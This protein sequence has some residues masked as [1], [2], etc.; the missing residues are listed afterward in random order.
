MRSLLPKFSLL[1]FS[2][3]I[4]LVLCEVLVRLFVPQQLIVRRPD[5]WRP[6]D[7]FGYR[8]RENIN[9]VL[10]RG[11]GN[12]HI[13]TDSHGY[14][15][16]QNRGANNTTPDIS[17]LVLG[18]S[19][20]EALAVENEFTIP[21]LI[22]KYLENKYK[23]T[24]QVDNAAVSGWDPNHYLLQARMSLEKKQYALGIVFLYIGN[25]IIS[26]KVYSFEA[27]IPRTESF[28][29]TLRLPKNLQLNEIIDAIFLPVSEYLQTQSHLFVLAKQAGRIPLARLGL[30]SSRYT[31][32]QIFDV[33]KVNL[34]NWRI[35]T[36]ICEE[37]QNE[38][39]R[40]GTPVFFV[41]L[42]TMMQVYE[43]VLRQYING[44]SIDP[45][46]IDSHQPNRMMKLHFETSGLLLVDPLEYMS[47]KAKSGYQMHG[48]GDRHFN[49]NGHQIVTEY[50]EPI[51][52]SY[53]KSSLGITA[54][55]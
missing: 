42:P 33:K 41:L 54:G 47:L 45:R 3:L 39:S 9:T 53:I 44:L 29:Q 35:T 18:D 26:K 25:D 2:T 13:V 50:I 10:N 30:T 22:R 4:T 17:I 31:G 46:L 7:T 19:F 5:I 49:K 23:K 32:Y 27:K 15:I 16:N 51:I 36:E 48:S 11:L 52:E 37:I 12:V 55:F 28:N 24:V 1:M 34:P 20:I 43:D 40:R 21:E 14:R 8:R 6:D 38:F